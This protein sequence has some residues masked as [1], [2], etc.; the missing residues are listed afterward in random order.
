MSNPKQIA[1]FSVKINGA[2]VSSDLALDIKQIVVD[3]NLYIP[4]MFMFEIHD[5]LDPNT[6]QPKWVDSSQLKIGAEV[7]VLAQKAQGNS[8]KPLSLMKGQ[9]TSLEPEFTN[10]GYVTIVVRGYDK[11]HKLSRTKKT[12]SF[13]KMSDSQIASKVA[14]GAGLQASV[15]STSVTYDYVLQYNQTDWEFLLGRARRIGYQLYVQENKLYFKKMATSG[16][17]IDL[18]WGET[19]L[20]FCPR[21]SGMRH[22]AEVEVRGWDSSK[23]QAIVATAKSSAAT[24]A[25]EIGEPTKNVAQKGFSATEK[26]VVVDQ[27]VFSSSEATALANALCADINADTVVADG[28]C[29]GNPDLKAGK[30]V[31]ITGVGARFS[32][33]YF[34]TSAK[35]TLVNGAHHTYFTISGSQPDT[36]NTLLSPDE[37]MMPYGAVRAVVTNINDPD[38]L[39][40]V[41]VKYPWMGQD[42]GKDAES[43][44][45]RVAWGG[46][47]SLVPEVNDEVLVVFEHGDVHQPYVIAAL[48]HKNTPPFHKDQLV[49]SGKVQQRVFHSRTGH[50]IVLDDSDDKPSIL[51]VDKTGKNKIFIDSKKNDMNINVAGNLTIEAEGN[52]TIKSKGNTSLESQGN[53]NTKSSGNTAIEATGTGK[54]KGNSLDLDG[55][56]TVN[57]K[58]SAAINLN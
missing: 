45:A 56:A 15:D 12:R 25:A 38:K 19:L 21:L 43:D 35:H 18:K 9:I 57:V 34:V 40:R 2:E 22:V 49:K 48:W 50:E 36:L 47:L 33:K 55:G 14:Q 53:I 31:K 30:H 5:P 20:S 24:S 17:T 41:K 39:G 23:Q 26:M 10:H 58:G 16:G 7:E 27:P 46:G 37:E 6:S 42:A 4:D 3:T 11:A 44:W 32:G 28:E 51:I 52:I 54:V 1:A 13:L 8:V 29:L